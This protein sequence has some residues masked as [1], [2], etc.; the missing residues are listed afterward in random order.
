MDPS[1][2]LE[3][4]KPTRSKLKQHAT[5]LEPFNIDRQHPT[6][7]VELYQSSAAARALVYGSDVVKWNRYIS[8]A[9]MLK[10]FFLF[11]FFC[12]LEKT[13]DFGPS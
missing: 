9:C 4:L 5:S 7:M 6:C 8:G 3:F 12:S 1:L 13:F 2:N 11:F 10:F